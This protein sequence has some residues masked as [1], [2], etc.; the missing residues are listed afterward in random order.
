MCTLAYE[1]IFIEHLLCARPLKALVS[2]ETLRMLH[3]PALLWA[4]VN[5]TTAPPFTANI[6]L[7]LLLLLLLM[8]MVGASAQPVADLLWAPPRLRD[9]RGM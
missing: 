4:L 3:F 8:I 6:I 9:S 2:L 7:L 1:K 5:T